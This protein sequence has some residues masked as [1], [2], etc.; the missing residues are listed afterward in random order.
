[1]IYRNS[2]LIAVLGAGLVLA[3]CGNPNANDIETVDPVEQIAEEPVAQEVIPAEWSDFEAG[4]TNP[5]TSDVFSRLDSDEDFAVVFSSCPYDDTG[6]NEADDPL[7][8]IRCGYAYYGSTTDGVTSFVGVLE[9]TGSIF[10]APGTVS[11]PSSAADRASV[12]VWGAP[13]TVESDGSVLDGSD[14]Q[15]GYVAFA[16]APADASMDVSDLDDLDMDAT[17][18]DVDVPQEETSETTEY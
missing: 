5:A 9:S 13:F 7:A 3:A 4:K 18:V 11:V 14:N 2:G 17:G 1:M 10:T 12:S 16:S 8:G 6:W 15:I